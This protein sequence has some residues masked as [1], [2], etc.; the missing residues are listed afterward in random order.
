[1]SREISKKDQKQNDTTEG[2]KDWHIW[3]ETNGMS[4]NENYTQYNLIGKAY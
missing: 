2:P 3:K 1:M 4:S